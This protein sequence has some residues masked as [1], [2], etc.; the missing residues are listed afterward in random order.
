MSSTRPEPSSDSTP[1]AGKTA[2]ITGA[3]KGIGRAVALAL[4]QR[5]VRII[6]VARGKA[7]LE[8]LDD[9]I[10]AEGGSATLVP[11][12]L[13]DPQ[14]VSQLCAQVLERFEQLDMVI[15]NT[16][17]LGP[18]GPLSAL[19]SQ[20]WNRILSVNLTAN[21]VLMQSLEARLRASK[22]GRALFVASDTAERH[23]AFW[24]AFAAS[25][26]A[27]EALVMAWA[28]EQKGTS[29]KVNLLDPGMTATDMY[30]EAFPGR[31]L[32]ALKTPNALVPV[33]L[34]LLDPESEYHAQ[35]IEAEAWL[36]GS[37]PK[38]AQD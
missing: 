2:L 7:A 33:F 15:G 34:A 12:D 31:D 35:R 14:A 19:S 38:L 21:L 9:A 16:A 36:A 17:T 26:A 28:K 25:K 11:L 18:L 27:L 20:A 3:S 32:S 37:G 29:L 6:A 30:A 22:A 4:A 23:P 13:A 24:G 1:F 10:R 5:G 8:S